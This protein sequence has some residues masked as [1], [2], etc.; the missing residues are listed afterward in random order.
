M[1][2]L[3]W[4]GGGG[5]ACKPSHEDFQEQKWRS[6]LRCGMFL[7]PEFVTLWIL[8]SGSRV[9]RHVHPWYHSSDRQGITLERH[10][11]IQSRGNSGIVTTTGSRYHVLIDVRD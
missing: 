6:H 2:A 5:C 1:R 10:S 3:G 7:L 11:S 8:T 4:V 9:L